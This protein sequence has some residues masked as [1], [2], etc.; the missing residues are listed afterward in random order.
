[1]S[2]Y[3]VEVVYDT[4]RYGQRHKKTIRYFLSS[5]LYPTEIRDIPTPSANS[6]SKGIMR[7]SYRTEFWL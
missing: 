7:R 6:L 4:C 2:P 5:F 3:S 1:M